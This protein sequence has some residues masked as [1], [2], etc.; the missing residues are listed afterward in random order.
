MCL[1]ERE[2]V[3]LG[4]WVVVAAQDLD[5]GICWH[6][7]VDH[8]FR[9]RTR[10]SPFNGSV[11]AFLRAAIGLD[12]LGQLI[13]VHTREGEIVRAARSPCGRRSGRASIAY[14]LM[15]AM[16]TLVSAYFRLATSSS[17]VACMKGEANP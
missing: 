12:R 2:A 10:K 6:C 4:L 15:T 13:P 5:D 11:L 7:S 3:L 9:I 16:R 1:L 8:D 14:K 17:A